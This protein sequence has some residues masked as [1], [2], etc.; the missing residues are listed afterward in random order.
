MSRNTDEGW[1]YGKVN[2]RPKRVPLGMRYHHRV[3][4]NHTTRWNF[5][6]VRINKEQ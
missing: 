6:F 2:G 1:Y 4:K 3:R 5:Q